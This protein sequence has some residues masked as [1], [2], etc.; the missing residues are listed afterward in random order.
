MAFLTCDFQNL[1]N[2]SMITGSVMQFNIIPSS[3]CLK[4]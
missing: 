1:C 3:K 4:L 2:Q